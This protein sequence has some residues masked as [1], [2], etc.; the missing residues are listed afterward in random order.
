MKFNQFF[1][2][3]GITA[4]LGLAACEKETISTPVEADTAEKANI[5]T[6][7]AAPDPT[8]VDLFVKDLKYATNI[9]FGGNTAYMAIPRSE[10]MKF[11]LAG[12]SNTIL[13][14]SSN[15]AKGK[16]YSVF[17]CG[18]ST[19]TESVIS[20]D[21]F[22]LSDVDSFTTQVRFVN[23][24]P[25]AMP[26]T[27]EMEDSAGVAPT[28]AT[29]IAYKQV[30]EFK[31]YKGC[32]HNIIITEAGNPNAIALYNIPLKSGSINTIYVKGYSNALYDPT[33]PNRRSARIITNRAS[34]L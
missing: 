7:N 3:F 34:K 32:A 13:N 33:N 11:N 9:L 17:M 29:N 4:V 10:T 15:F 26:I 12:K 27:V 2:I 31:S 5:M 16:N 6:V 14:V 18:D 8:G 20:E 24:S 22:T 28:L 19:K 1:G 23:L 30:S 25:D 21:V